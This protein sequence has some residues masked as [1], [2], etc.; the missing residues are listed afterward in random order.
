MARD[1][2]TSVNTVSEV[3]R[4]TIAIGLLDRDG[5]EQIWQEKLHKAIT[6]NTPEILA[7]VPHASLTANTDQLLPGGRLTLVIRIRLH[8]SA[9][10]MVHDAKLGSDLRLQQKMVEKK[11]PA[12]DVEDLCSLM[13]DNFVDV[14]ANVV[15]VFED[16]DQKCHTFPLATRNGLTV[17]GVEAIV[18][19]RSEVQK[20]VFLKN[21]NE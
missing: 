18:G 21:S 6:I 3:F 2:V 4:A 9:A 12:P 1:A 11:L 15:L 17:T 13:L 19:T 14:G 20:K 7:A 16:G 10:T 5:V 8:A